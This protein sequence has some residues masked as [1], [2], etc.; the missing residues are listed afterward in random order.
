MAVYVQVVSSWCDDGMLGGEPSTS[1][2]TRDPPMLS[3]FLV[4]EVPKLTKVS[5]DGALTAMQV[6]KCEHGGA[7]RGMQVVAG[8]CWHDVCVAM[9]Q[10]PQRPSPQPEGTSSMRDAGNEETGSSNGGSSSPEQQ[11]TTPQSGS[12]HLRTA[13][14]APQQECSTRHATGMNS[15]PFREGPQTMSVGPG[16]DSQEPSWDAHGRRGGM[17]GEQ[18]GDSPVNNSSSSMGMSSSSSSGGSYGAGS[19]SMRNRGIVGPHGDWTGLESTVRAT[20]TMQQLQDLLRGYT[21]G[22]LTP[23]ELV[24]FCN[25]LARIT[26]ASRTTVR[27]W[28]QTQV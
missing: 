12:A 10:A 2:A 27:V 28:S 8:A 4:P 11:R 6:C 19:K 15:F 21:P 17:A 7:V 26:D 16:L 24:L 5:A 3:V 18:V 13:P 14:Q 1:D 20:T 9:P 22:K 23:P 25:H